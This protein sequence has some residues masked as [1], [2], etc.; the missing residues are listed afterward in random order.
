MD[1][2]TRQLPA[3]SRTAN[4]LCR[5]GF[6]LY[7]NTKVT[8]FPDGAPLLRDI[9]DRA[10][11]AERFIFLEYF[12][13]A[14]GKLWDELEKILCAKARAGVEVKVIFDDFGNIKRFSGETIDPSARS[15]RRGLYLQPRARVCQPPVLSIT[16]TTARSP[17]STAMSAYTGGA[18]IADEYAN[19]IERYGYWKDGGVRL[20]GEGAWGLTRKLSSSMCV[21]IGG[22]M[23]DEHD[24][25][26]PHTPVKS[27]GYCQPF[28]DGPQNNPD[29][30]AEDVF[31][32]DD[33]H[34]AALSLYH[35]ALFYPR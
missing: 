24:Y 11:K 23:H 29:N 35:N 5:R 8:Y 4:F 33:L 31:L 34:R 26:R 28:V 20:E 15:G 6:R 12:I 9:I 27:D 3:W 22:V 21:N 30:P 1:K 14:E 25:Y 19:I 13:L 17:A 10:G 16:A 18:N 32:A 2:L 7:Q